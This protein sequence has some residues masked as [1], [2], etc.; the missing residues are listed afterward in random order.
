MSATTAT[1]STI[2]SMCV[3]LHRE[4]SFHQVDTRVLKSALQ[5]Y[6]RRAMLSKGLWCLIELDLFSLLECEPA[7]YSS[8]NELRLKP[9]QI[10]MNAR[11]LR[12]NLIN[13]MVAMIS[14]D[15]GPVQFDLP[16]KVLHWFKNWNEQRRDLS[17][18]RILVEFYSAIANEQTPRI[19]LISDLRTVF[20]LPEYLTKNETLHRKLL[21]QFQMTELSEI[22][23]GDTN[24]RKKVQR[25]IFSS[26]LRRLSLFD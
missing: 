3:V 18:R 5:K 6:G 24:R 15:V 7:L 17:S 13:R 2:G 8:V 4:R 20:N 12:S 11:R 1:T 23:Y 19:R 26:F 25:K 9:G 22:L 14:E 16:A 21:E 10:S